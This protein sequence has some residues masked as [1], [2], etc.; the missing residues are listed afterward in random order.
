[1]L[2]PHRDITSEGCYRRH[3][4]CGLG[5][6]LD[7]CGYLFQGFSHPN[8][9]RYGTSGSKSESNAWSGKH[10]RH[11][12]YDDKKGKQKMPEYEMLDDESKNI[13]DVDSDASL[14]DELG[15]GA[16]KISG[17]EKAMKDVDQKLRRSGRDKKTVERF[18]Y[19][20]YM[21]MHYAY[22]SKVVQ[23]P[24]PNSFDEAKSDKKWVNAM[25]EEIVH[26]LKTE[27]G[28]W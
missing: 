27:H 28:I 1:M 9:W 3:R 19:D 26:W 23:I 10:A 5:F 18:G 7:D 22:M 20:T 14:D 25:Q 12:K 13:E 11:K 24:D 17:M 16:L 15:I 2:C 21:A 6:R 4:W 8:I